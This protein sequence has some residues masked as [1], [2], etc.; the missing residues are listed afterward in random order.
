MDPAALLAEAQL[1]RGLLQNLQSKLQD[2]SLLSALQGALGTV[3]SLLS[4]V[5]GAP[6]VPAL[7]SLGGLNGV[8]SLLDFTGLQNLGAAGVITGVTLPASLIV[9]DLPP[10]TAQFSLVH[11][12]VFFCVSLTLL[13]KCYYDIRP[14]FA[15]SADLM[16]MCSFLDHMIQ[17]SV[18]TRIDHLRLLSVTDL[19]YLWNVN[20][21][22]IM[23]AGPLNAVF[24]IAPNALPQ[25]GLA[26]GFDLSQLTGSFT[27]L[28]GI[29]QQLQSLGSSGLTQVTGTLV[30]TAATLLGRATDLCSCML[31]PLGVVGQVVNVLGSNGLPST[32]ATAIPPLPP[33]HACN[34]TYTQ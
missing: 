5:G 17:I 1:V 16:H 21:Y 7:P 14:Y 6:N 28:N 20:L 24:S 27:N 15:S 31:T 8:L 4:S 2:G 19:Q 29:Q 33:P 23:G 22:G 32:G 30:G 10:F 13:V 34:T 25:L 3:N 11:C 12:S 9:P 26:P 18:V